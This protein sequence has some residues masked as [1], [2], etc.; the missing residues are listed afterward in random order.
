MPTCA[1]AGP[2]HPRPT[3]TPGATRA[4]LPDSLQLGLYSDRLN[5]NRPG[6]QC[7]A[8][9]ASGPPWQSP[10]PAAA[11][12][13]LATFSPFYPGDEPSGVYDSL[14]SYYLPLLAFTPP[15]RPGPSIVISRC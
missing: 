7:F 9:S 1:S 8:F 12:Q 15:E 10:A 14:D 3:P 13:V 5:V 4:P 6:S 2:P 11:G